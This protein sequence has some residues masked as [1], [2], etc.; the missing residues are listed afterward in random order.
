MIVFIPQRASKLMLFLFFFL[1]MTACFS[2]SASHLK[3]YK[4]QTIILPNGKSFKVY[5]AKSYKEQKQGLST[6]KDEDFSADE[7]M[8]FTGHKM[9]MRQF[10]MPNTH[11][12]LDIIFLNAD[13]YVL[14]I[15]RN[16]EHFKEA[17][18]RAKVPM[19]KEVYAQHILEIKSDSPLAK[20]IKIGQ[21]LKWNNSKA[22]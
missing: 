1:Y 12:N 16:L 11:F 15:H 8:F 5:M 6:I 4:H 14:D 21:I 13:L 17:G 9:Y 7:G 20:K 3:E 18:P 10:W 22:K 2:N 19:S